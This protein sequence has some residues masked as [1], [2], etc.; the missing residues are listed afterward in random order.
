M[1]LISAW[2]ELLGGGYLIPTVG[3]GTSFGDALAASLAAPPT[4]T[5]TILTLTDSG[6][7]GTNRTASGKLTGAEAVALA[8]VPVSVAY[9][10]ANGS[11][12]TYRLSGL[13]PASAFFTH[14]WGACSRA[15][16]RGSPSARLR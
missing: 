1:V 3:Y 11:V 9:V 16:P 10:P 5:G 4:K 2:N 8:G 6:P 14:W 7:S 15:A 12:S 13:A